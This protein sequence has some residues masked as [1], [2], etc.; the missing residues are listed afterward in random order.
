[1]DCLQQ[2]RALE[3]PGMT[4]LN[5]R[6]FLKLSLA[7]PAAAALSARAHA[8]GKPSALEGPRQPNIIIIVLDTMSGK[9]LSLYGYPRPTT[10]NFERFAQRAHVF[11]AHH[12]AGNF[13]VPGTASILTG[14]YPWTHRAINHSGFIAREL[15]DRNMFRLLGESYTRLAFSQNLWAV[16]LLAQFKGDVDRFLP[17][18]SFSFTGQVLGERFP[19][20]MQAAYL[21]L[22]EF[23]FWQTEPPPSMIFGIPERAALSRKAVHAED[24][25]TE[26]PAGIPSTT[27]LPFYFRLEELYGGVLQTIRSLPGPYLAYIHLWGVHLPYRPHGRFFKKGLGDWEPAEKPRH[28]LGGKN[29]Y[30]DQLKKLRRYDEYIASTDYEFGKLMDQLE[31]DGTLDDSYVFVTADHGESFERGTQG[32]TTPLLFEPLIHI[33]LMVSTPRHDKRV[34]VVT[35]T[36]SVDILPTLAAITGTNIPEW[37]EGRP[38]PGIGGTVDPSRR[39][40]TVEA[41]ATPARGRMEKSSVALLQGRYKLVH[42]RGYDYDFSE[43]YDLVDDPEELENLYERRPA[44]AKPLEEELLHRLEL[45]GDQLVR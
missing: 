19:N 3:R 11:H 4:L 36:S 26:Y 42:Y 23:L 16:H 38:L 2:H 21:A 25:N 7:L 31:Q 33:P 32:H 8:S 28:Q 43:L 39:V 45:A 27:L 12:S 15:A 34:D 9:N 17:P 35:P 24:D 13:T 40:F 5:R 14:M 1:M 37:C 18:T 29:P 44:E 30:I 22:D 41:K 6:D 20:D 10:P